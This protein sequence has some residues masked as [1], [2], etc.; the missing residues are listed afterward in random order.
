M[1]EKEIL[2]ESNKETQFYELKTGEI[3]CMIKD[4][5]QVLFNEALELENFPFDVVSNHPISH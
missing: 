5:V 1:N 3:M 2:N 4:S